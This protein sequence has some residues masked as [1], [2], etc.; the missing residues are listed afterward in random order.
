LSVAARPGSKYQS[1]KHDYYVEPA[2]E[3]APWHTRKLQLLY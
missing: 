2:N 1:A 3:K